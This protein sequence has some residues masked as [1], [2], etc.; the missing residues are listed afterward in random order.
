MKIVDAD[1]EQL[2]SWSNGEREQL[3]QCMHILVSALEATRDDDLAMLRLRRAIAAL[4]DVETGLVVIPAR[5]RVE[6]V[7]GEDDPNS[8]K[9]RQARM[10]Q[11]IV[12]ASEGIDTARGRLHDIVHEARALGVSWNR[13]GAVLNITRQSARTRFSN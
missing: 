1:G 3:D 7:E 8:I 6:P 12:L 11:D 13:I 10:L 2:V 5:L 4:R 9:V